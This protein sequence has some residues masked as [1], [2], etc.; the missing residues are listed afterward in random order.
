M[1]TLL[2]AT[3][4]GL[5]YYLGKA[6][7]GYHLSTALC[8]PIFSGFVLGLLTGQIEKG[9]LIGA[10]IQL[11]YLGVIST[12]G[13]L[14]AD[15]GLAATVS[16]PIALLSG[17]DAD[18]AVGLAVPFAVL[19][20]FIDQIRRTTNSI[21]VRRADEYAEKGDRK[22]IF[23]CAVIYP[24]L[25]GFCLRFI[26]VFCINMIGADAVTHLLEVL[27]S[28]IITGFSVA[29]GLLPALGFA[30]IILTIGRNELLP[31]F[32]IGFFA[33]GYLGINTMAAAVFGIC[34][35]VLVTLN[36]RKN[37]KEAN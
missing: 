20:V 29:G 12:G 24:S 15:Q 9:L 32:F 16:I 28:W 37:K 35:A 31:Y 19:G 11:V 17:M 1:N 33:V 25:V 14:P 7:I 21:W 34:I 10:S 8:S 6:E 27:P 3:I 36:A 5:L 4:S 30:I 2:I 26:P 22:E 13:N 23:K 18:V